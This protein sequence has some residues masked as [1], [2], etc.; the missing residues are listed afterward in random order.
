MCGHYL[1]HSLLETPKNLS[2]YR[3][4]SYFILIQLILLYLVVKA[5]TADR[6][7]NDSTTYLTELYYC[8]RQL[9]LV[10][11]VTALFHYVQWLLTIKI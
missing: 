1:K 2:P 9:Y 5:K 3:V 6:H 8:L 7:C 4:I 11:S 10:V